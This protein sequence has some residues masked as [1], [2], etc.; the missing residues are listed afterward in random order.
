MVRK[1]LAI[2][3]IGSISSC[4]FISGDNGVLRDRRQTYKDAEISP[5]M[6]IPH[7]LDSYT[8]DQLYVIPSQFL[9]DAVPF[10]DV[11]MPEPI[12]TKRREGVIIQNLGERRWIVLDATPAQVWP[13]VRDFW[14]QL[15]VSLDY[16]N[17]T[18]GLMETAWVEVNAEPLLRH[19]YRIS[20]EP[21]LHSGYAEI[22]VTHLSNLRSE[23]IPVLVNWPDSSESEDRERQIMD[24]VSQYLADRNDVYQASTSSLLA[25]SIDAERKANIV[26]ESN[27]QEKLR[28]RV[29]YNRAWV[30]VRQ[31]IERAEVEILETDRGEAKIVVNFSGIREQE[32]KAG[33]FRRLISRGEKK[34]DDQPTLQLTVRITD[35]DDFVE[36][37]P[38]TSNRIDESSEIDE[39]FHELL[40]VIYENLS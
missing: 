19:K 27:G 5:V 30:Q 18:S 10:E 31:A 1:F 39:L 3:I 35:V 25:G 12:E 20:I 22:Y 6:E 29:D 23:P 15:Q 16:E 8:I 24:A 36:I 33:F 40:T 34:A 26:T 37:T 2:I 7:S 13:L 17:P 21:G 38:E 14:A 32:I 9:T 28:L 4:S 11:P